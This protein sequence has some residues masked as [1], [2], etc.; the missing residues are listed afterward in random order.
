MKV[1]SRSAGFSPL[2][3]PQLECSRKSPARSLAWSPPKVTKRAACARNQIVSG[4]IGRGMELI[5]LPTIPLPCL[6]FLVLL[7]V[8]TQKSKLTTSVRPILFAPSR[9]GVLAIKKEPQRRQGA[10][11]QRRTE[12]IF[13]ARKG[14]GSVPAGQELLWQSLRAE[15]GAEDARSPDAPRDSIAD[16]LREASGVRWIYHCFVGRG[17]SR[18]ALDPAARLRCHNLVRALAAWEFFKPPRSGLFVWPATPR[19]KNRPSKISCKTRLR[20]YSCFSRGI[21][22]PLHKFGQVVRRNDETLLRRAKTDK[23]LGGRKLHVTRILNGQLMRHRELR[24]V[25]EAK[26]IT[27]SNNQRS[28]VM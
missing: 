16:D 2:Q 15:S 12:Q 17:V 21:S 14:R 28:L 10:M 26:T 5:P 20:S 19:S 3:R 6:Q 13:A 24:Q 27:F 18:A 23:L 4:M 9:L 1:A 22:P 11:P 8:R 25:I 7:N